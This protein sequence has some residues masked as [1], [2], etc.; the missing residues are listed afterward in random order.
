M[1]IKIDKGIPSDVITLAMECVERIKAGEHV[2]HKRLKLRG[3]GYKSV[4]IKL[5]YRLLI[6]DGNKCELLHHE[7]YNKRIAK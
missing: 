3:K 1:R 2:D 6:V 4:K 5:R 7:R